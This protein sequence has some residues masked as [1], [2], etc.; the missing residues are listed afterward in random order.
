MKKKF[1][2]LLLIVLALSLSACGPDAEEIA[3]EAAAMVYTSV[4]ETMTAMPTATLQPTATPVPATPTQ[5]IIPTATTDSQNGNRGQGQG[6]QGTGVPTITTVSAA[7]LCKDAVYVTDVTI[8]DNTVFAPGVSFEKTWSILNAGTCTWDAGYT[9]SFTSGETM[10]GVAVPLTSAVAPNQ[11]VSVSV[12]MTA[13]ATAGTYTS[14]WQMSDTSGVKFGNTI[15][16]QIIVS[17]DVATAT[18][19][20]TATATATTV[21]VPT[22]TPP[23]T[24][25]P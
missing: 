8:P 24:A 16:V 19:I 21:V 20:A 6:G 23:P 17:G 4:A 25:I 22:D 5:I 12:Q 18:S 14:Y 15:F 9:L 10:S 2:I 11:Q 1:L 13:P 7:P 3:A